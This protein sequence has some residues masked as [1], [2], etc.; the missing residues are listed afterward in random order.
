M[1]TVLFHTVRQQSSV[2]DQLTF[3]QPHNH[4]C[5][6]INASLVQH[7]LPQQD[8]ELSVFFGPNSS[9]NY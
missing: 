6:C 1:E 9:P 4:S 5:P 2:H 7:K 3:L 8:M